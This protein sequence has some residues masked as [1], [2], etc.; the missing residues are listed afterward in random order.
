MVCLE[1][2]HTHFICLNMVGISQECA[3]TQISW[4]VDVYAMNTPASAQAT[5]SLKDGNSSRHISCK[6]PRV[7]AAQGITADHKLQFNRTCS[8]SQ[9][10]NMTVSPPCPPTPRTVLNFHTKISNKPIAIQERGFNLPCSQHFLQ[11]VYTVMRFLLH[12]PKL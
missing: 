4:C 12:F 3:L 9:V 7:G 5:A 1:M 2:H 6:S 11:H 10:S 8:S